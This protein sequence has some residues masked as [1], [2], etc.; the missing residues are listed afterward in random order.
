MGHLFSDTSELYASPVNFSREKAF[1][2]KRVFCKQIGLYLPLCISLMRGNMRGDGWI[3]FYNITVFFIT[4][5]SICL[6]PLRVESRLM[7]FHLREICGWEVHF[8]K[9]RLI[10]EI[11]QGE[12]PR[13]VRPSVLEEPEKGS[14]SHSPTCYCS[15]IHA[16]HGGGW[17]LGTTPCRDSETGTWLWPWK[18]LWISPLEERNLGLLLGLQ[19]LQGSEWEEEQQGQTCR[20]RP[21]EEEVS[22]PVHMMRMEKGSGSRRGASW[23]PW[24]SWCSGCAD[25]LP[26]CLSSFQICFSRKKRIIVRK[27][28]LHDVDISLQLHQ[29]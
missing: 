5:Y 24:G 3:L 15:H 6:S 7:P 8:Q 22:K 11:M 19:E 17:G 25:F 29:R 27:H 14:G 21:V 1:P 28:R 13:T 26:C 23:S 2:W 9:L 4:V 16:G 18:H 10:L 12:K 20:D